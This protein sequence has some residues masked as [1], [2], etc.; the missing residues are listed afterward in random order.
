[1][2]I[3][4]SLGV[5]WTL[6]VHMVCFG[7]A[8]IFLT[9]L[10]LKPY[11][12]AMHEREKRTQGNE[13]MAVRIIE[14]ADKLQAHYEQRAKALNAEIK[15]YFD[16]SRT[17]AMSQYDQMVTAARNEANTLI[18]STQTKIEDQIQKARSAVLA[19]VPAVSA[20]IASKLAG[21][22]ISL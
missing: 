20:A 12:A 15:G 2:N 1:M 21:K 19:E 10:V 7:I 4:S 14:E 3:L 6:V 13:E 5:D 8:Y 17:E 22:E 11:A 9:N 16:E 18:K